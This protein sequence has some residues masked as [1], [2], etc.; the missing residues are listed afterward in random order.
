MPDDWSQI[1]GAAEPNR[2]RCRSNAGGTCSAP[3]SG[4]R[5]LPELQLFIATAQVEQPHPN[6]NNRTGLPPRLNA[7]VSI[8]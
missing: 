7:W 1:L 6:P 3:A 4:L 2:K 8:C 5:V